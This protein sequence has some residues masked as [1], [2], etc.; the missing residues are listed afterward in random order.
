MVYYV[1]AI[2]NGNEL[3]KPSATDLIEKVITI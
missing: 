3:M 2:K 1:G